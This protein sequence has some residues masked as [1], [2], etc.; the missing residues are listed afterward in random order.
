MA[1]PTKALEAAKKSETELEPAVVDV[2]PAGSARELSLQTMIQTRQATVLKLSRLARWLVFFSIA[3]ALGSIAVM[4]LQSLEHF[5]IVAGFAVFVL[6]L[7]LWLHA[8]ARFLGQGLVS[9]RYTGTGLAD[10]ALPTRQRE[11]L[12][13][14][15][16][17]Y[18]AQN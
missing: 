13:R 16:D 15:A 4:F 10:D 12:M 17:E 18:L 8:R 14:K 6:G 5:L 2:S 9:M 11:T 7:A 1:L 3:I